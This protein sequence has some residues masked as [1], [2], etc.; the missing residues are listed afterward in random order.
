MESLWNVAN[1]AQIVV[2]KERMQEVIQT[3]RR[4]IIGGNNFSDN[5]TFSFITKFVKKNYKKLS[6]SCSE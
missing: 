5:A 6:G 4:N 2:T 3:K 1:V